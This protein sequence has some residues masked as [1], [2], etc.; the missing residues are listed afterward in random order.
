MKP[1][2][3]G[4][5]RKA[6]IAAVASAS[7]GGCA[8]TATQYG[9]PGYGHPYGNTQRTTTTVDPVVAAIG[10]AVIAGAVIA[11]TREDEYHH[12]RTPRVYYTPAP[13]YRDYHDRHHRHGGH[14]HHRH[15]NHR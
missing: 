7:L 8:V 15:H 13:T 3:S 11:N 4:K 10:V 12:R 6:F 14:R 9:D 2:D 1:F 5:L